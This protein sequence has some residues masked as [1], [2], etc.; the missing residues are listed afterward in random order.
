MKISEEKFFLSIAKLAAEQSRGLRLKVGGVVTDALGNIVATG[1]NGNIRGGSNELERRIYAEDDE[2]DSWCDPKD[3]V[4][5]YVDEHNHSYRLVTKDTVIHAEMNIIAHAARRG[6][7][8][9]DGTMFLTHSP[10]MHCCSMLIQSGIKEVIFI[11][12]FRTFQEVYD[13]YHGHIIINQGWR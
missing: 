7:S 10:C 1:Y 3:Q 2:D 13:Q 12:K 4:Y 9:N 6:I 5:P 11:E 8:I